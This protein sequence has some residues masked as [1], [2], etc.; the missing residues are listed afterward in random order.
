MST[1]LLEFVSVIFLGALVGLA[2][3]SP[4]S[5]SSCKCQ[6]AGT[7]FA[8]PPPSKTMTSGGR[9]L[10]ILDPLFNVRQ[11]CK[12]L[13]L[14]QD[15]LSLP[16]MKCKQCIM[17]HFLYLEGYAEEA[18]T[19][20]AKGLHRELLEPLPK[21]IRDMQ[22][23]YTSGADSL[24]LAQKMRELRRKLTPMAFLIGLDSDV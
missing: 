10:P 14:L 16:G 22:K 6:H 8:N 21:A 23:D 20:D 1:G 18:I 11:I 12:H 15:H 19:L 13:L 7:V 17:K 9:L 5:P 24:V 4:S 2:S 3:I